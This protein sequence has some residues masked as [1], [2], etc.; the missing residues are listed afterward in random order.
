MS[1]EFQLLAKTEFKN[2]FRCGV[3]DVALCWIAMNDSLEEKCFLDTFDLDEYRKG[4]WNS[5]EYDVWKDGSSMMFN[6]WFCCDRWAASVFEMI[7]LYLVGWR[8]NLKWRFEIGGNFEIFWFFEGRK[9]CKCSALSFLIK[10][11]VDGCYV[12]WSQY[13][14]H[15]RSFDIRTC[16]VWFVYSMYYT[17]VL[18][19]VHKNLCKLWYQL[20]VSR[21]YEYLIWK[22]S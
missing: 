9:W 17:R 2:M 12:G 19:F 20:H 5:R 11:I 7:V 15:K 18:L 16:Y 8:D 22:I 3:I 1:R 14:V 13:Y 21:F 6:N 4:M 10:K